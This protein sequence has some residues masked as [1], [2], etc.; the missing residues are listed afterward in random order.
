MG[1]TVHVLAA[2]EKRYINLRH[3][4]IKWVLLVGAME[5]TSYVQQHTSQDILFALLCHSLL[6]LLVAPSKVTLSPPSSSKTY[7]LSTSQ[8][9][10]ARS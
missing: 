1:Q 3:L 4:L 6:L 2:S 10:N 7:T 5:L 9:A 8:S